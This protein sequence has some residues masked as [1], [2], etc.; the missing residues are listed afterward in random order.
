MDNM[1]EMSSDKKD[2]ML[3]KIYM[4]VKGLNYKKRR[5]TF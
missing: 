4:N 1:V 3:L 2:D 5:I